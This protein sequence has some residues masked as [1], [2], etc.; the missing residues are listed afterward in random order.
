METIFQQPKN[1][2]PQINSV[3]LY[4]SVD[5]EDGNEGVVGAPFAGMGCLPLIAADEA[6]LSQLTPIAEKM[7]KMGKMKIQLIRLSHREVIKEINP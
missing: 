1:T 7:A 3:Y 4:V 2:L 5:P 6:R